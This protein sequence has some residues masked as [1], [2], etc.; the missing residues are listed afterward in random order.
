MASVD[1]VLGETKGVIA[2]L[3]F[4][5]CPHISLS[6]GQVA[7]I[8][9]R[10]VVLGNRV[11]FSFFFFLLIAEQAAQVLPSPSGKGVLPYKSALNDCL[12]CASKYRLSNMP[13]FRIRRPAFLYGV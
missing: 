8:V 10:V 12:C 4:F 7:P 9:S 13:F 2:S 11:L 5:F 1:A 3:A 6:S